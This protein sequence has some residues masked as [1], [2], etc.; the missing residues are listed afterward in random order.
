MNTISELLSMRGWAVEKP[1]EQRRMR[2]G[3]QLNL[4]LETAYFKFWMDIG[5]VYQLL[6][7]L[8]SGLWQGGHATL[9]PFSIKI[10]ISRWGY[11]TL[12][13]FLGTFSYRRG[14]RLHH[15][16]FFP[17]KRQEH[18]RIARIWP[19]QLWH[20]SPLLFKILM[21]DFGPHGHSGF[22]GQCA[23]NCQVWNTLGQEVEGECFVFFPLLQFSFIC[24]YGRVDRWSTQRGHRALNCGCC[25]RSTRGGHRRLGAC[26]RTIKVRP[27]ALRFDGPGESY[28]ENDYIIPIYKKLWDIIESS[29]SGD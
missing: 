13:L 10:H 20:L 25:T 1:M 11:T 7:F 27:D 9:F 29:G 8:A 23:N 5:R 22:Q 4:S 3:G 26:G 2:N 24:C 21:D 16:L 6:T 18:M 17:L 19:T 28:E 15:V 12:L 14:Q